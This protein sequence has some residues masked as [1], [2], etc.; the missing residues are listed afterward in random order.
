MAQKLYPRVSHR[1]YDKKRHQIGL[2][3]DVIKLKN[4]LLSSYQ[5]WQTNMR[6]VISHHNRTSSSTSMALWK[7]V[8]T[9]TESTQYT[10]S[11]VE[12]IAEY[13]TA[14]KAYRFKCSLMCSTTKELTRRTLSV[15][16]AG[17]VVFELPSITSLDQHTSQNK[18]YTRILQQVPNSR[19]THE[20]TGTRQ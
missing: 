20:N 5:K 6:E 10:K 8:Q 1:Y 15:Y 4:L 12:P 3:N 17:Y 11:V 9:Y 19:L 2:E 14:A 16:R 13:I 7:N 18:V